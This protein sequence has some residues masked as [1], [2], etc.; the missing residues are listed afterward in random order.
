MAIS[1]KIV[2]ITKN[3]GQFSKLKGNRPTAASRVNKIIRSIQDVGYITNPIIVNEKM[4]VIDGQGRLEAMKRLNLPV[5][6]IVEKGAGINECVAMNINQTNW[7]TLDYV[8]SYAEQGIKDYKQLEQFYEAYRP[9]VIMDALITICGKRKACGNNASTL[10]KDGTFKFAESQ[11]EAVRIADYLSSFKDFKIM[12]PNG[13]RTPVTSIRAF[14]N[15]LIF[16]ARDPHID[17]N[18]LRDNL[19]KYV[20]ELP[21]FSDTPT[22]LQAFEF[23]YNKRLSDKSK[24]FFNGIYKQYEQQF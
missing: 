6:Y 7:T 12:K 9:F 15:C 5:E 10:V 13:K 19:F 11:S 23:I 8:R 4:E 3:Y 1:K 20:L 2:F 24:L 21:P 22:C 17:E 18:R 14:F 16:C